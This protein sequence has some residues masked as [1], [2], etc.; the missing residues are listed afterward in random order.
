MNAVFGWRRDAAALLAFGL[1]SS[2]VG[3][4]AAQS[5]SAAGGRGRDST[6]F[7]QIVLPS[8]IMVD[9]INALMIALNREALNSP[10]HALIRARIDSLA[11]ALSEMRTIIITRGPGGREGRQVLVTPGRGGAGMGVVRRSDAPAGWIGITAQGPK[12]DRVISGRQLVEYLDYPSV[13]SVDPG[14]PAQR[15][16]IIPGDVV[17]AYDGADL[18][19]HVFN[20]AQIFQPERKLA[21]TVR[22]D[23]EPKDLMLIVAHTPDDIMRRRRDLEEGSVAQA[24][25]MAVAAAMGGGMPSTFLFAP[26]GLFGMTLA[27]VNVEL[28]RALNRDPGVLVTNAPD[29]SPGYRNGLRT[30]DV[31]V[32]V[33]GGTLTPTVVQLQRIVSAHDDD[34]SVELQVVRDKKTRKITLTW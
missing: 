25:R 28:G 10:D 15:A 1:A 29:G 19:S 33:G 34:R 9:S 11:A 21:I 18:R 3:P 5:G 20:L 17:L 4:A 14:S 13:V 23:G 12:N 30:G 8:Q 6:V 7:Y 27:N 26:N 22:R 2:L 24:Q 32:S 16:G 31:I